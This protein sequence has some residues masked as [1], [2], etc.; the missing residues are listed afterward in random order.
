MKLSKTI[1]DSV[2]LAVQD[3]S[4]NAL[5]HYGKIETAQV[6]NYLVVDY[7]ILFWDITLLEELI[8][9]GLQDGKIQTIC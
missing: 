7:G 6:Q 3:C 8:K 5:F 9:G 1:P 2:K 4:E